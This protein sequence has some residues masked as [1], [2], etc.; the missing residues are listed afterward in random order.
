MKKE[1]AN[2]TRADVAS[3]ITQIKRKKR[4]FTFE[5]VEKESGVKLTTSDKFL[6]RSI[7]EKKFKMDVIYETP[8]NQLKFHPKLK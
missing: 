5:D 1:I 7:V 8:E 2:F 6:I 4:A 3:L